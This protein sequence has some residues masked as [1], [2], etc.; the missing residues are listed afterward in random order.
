VG[1]SVFKFSWGSPIVRE[2]ADADQQHRQGLGF[3]PLRSRTIAGRAGTRRAKFAIVRHGRVTHART[4]IPSLAARD[5][6]PLTIGLLVIAYAVLWLIARPPGEPIGRHVGQL[7]GAESVLLLS[8]ALVLISTL[9]RVEVWFDGIDRAAIW[10]RRAAI[11]GLLLLVPHVM[12]SSN[13]G[14]AGLGGPLGAI[15]LTGLIALAVWAV[16]PR[17]QAFVPPPLRRPIVAVRDAMPV[18][19]LSRLLGGY[20]RWRTLH[21]TT[22]LFV[23]VGFAHGLMNATAFAGAPILRWSYIAIGGIGLAFYVYREVLARFFWPMHDYQVDSVRVIDK[24]LVVVAL[25]PV[26][27][28]LEFVPGQFAMVFLEAKDGW[29]RHPFTL[30]SG[31]HESLIRITV[32]ALGDYTSRLD[33]ILERGMPAVISGPHGRF[34][35]GTG[36][37]RQVWIAAGVGVAPFL[38]WLRSLDGSF[39]QEV[40]L[41]YTSAGEAPFA[42]EILA[43]A[44]R[45]PSLRVHLID[46]NAQGRL[47]PEHVLATA[48]GATR[49]LSVYMCGPE[50]MLRHF[51]SELRRAGVHRTR[52]H[53]EY[54]DWR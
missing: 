4:V 43:T 13:P 21:R 27:R 49:D 48:G 16:L 2:M 39:D 52:I 53:R 14:G 29:H 10:H 40:D 18:R 8:V 3:E 11:A 7:F 32:K 12:L 25:A 41:F 20:E 35:R 30:A 17:W 1:V 31:P 45:H 38:S 44:R 37:E 42:D 28:P 5:V 50:P 47:K 46:T 15:G 19:K 6:G 26:G 23:A 9:P 51:Q 54:F 22:G 33:K 36:T 24:G 34:D